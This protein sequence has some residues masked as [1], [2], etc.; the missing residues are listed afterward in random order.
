MTIEELISKAESGDVKAQCELGYKYYYGEEDPFENAIAQIFKIFEN[1]S[2]QQS[3][4]KQNS[5]DQSYLCVDS[6]KRDYAE[7]FK[8]YKK[9]AEQGYA[10]GQFKLGVMYDHGEGVKQDYIEAFK[11]F[12]KAAEQGYALAQCALGYKY[13]NGSGTEKDYTEAVKWYKKAAEQGDLRA[14]SNLGGMYAIIGDFVEAEI[15]L[16]KAA[17][18]GDAVAQ[19]NLGFIYCFG[20][21]VEIDYLE[22]LKWYTKSAEQNYAKA[23]MALGDCYMYGRGVE[24]NWEQAEEWYRRA[25]KNGEPSARD[26]IAQMTAAGYISTYS[27]R[28]AARQGLEEAKIALAEIEKK[29]TLTSEE[30]FRIAH[31]GEKHDVFISWN[32]LDKSIKDG[33]VE[34]IE[35]FAF[36]AEH[37]GERIV[38]KFRA[39]ESDRDAFGDDVEKCIRAA[40]NSAKVFIVILTKNSVDSSWVEKEVGFALNRV[41]AGELDDGDIVVLRAGDGVDEAL[42][43]LDKDSPLLKLKNYAADFCGQAIDGKT[44]GNICGRIQD[45]LERQ[46]VLRY[47]RELTEGKENF[48]CAMYGQPKVAEGEGILNQTLSF[49]KGYIDR[50]LV[51]I[52]AKDIDIV[53]VDEILAADYPF[54]IT[55]EGGVGKSLFVEELIRTRFGADGRF[56]VRINIAEYAEKIAEAQNL[57]DIL[58][59]ELNRYAEK[60]DFKSQGSFTR[61][62]GVND[63]NKMYIVIDG[64]DETDGTGR[65]KLIGLIKDYRRRYGGDRF[66]FTARTDEYFGELNAVLGQNRLRCFKLAALTD[67]DR[68]KLYDSFLEAN[69]VFQSGIKRQYGGESKAIFFDKLKDVPKN[70]CEN[71]MLFSNLVCIYLQGRGQYFPETKYEIISKA[72]E[73]VLCSLKDCAALPISDQ[74]KNYL[75]RDELNSLLGY[76]AYMKLCGDARN[77]SEVIS[78]YV[79]DSDCAEEIY[80]FLTRRRILVANKIAHDI[81]TCYFAGNYI[82]GK[83]YEGIENKVVFRGEQGKNALAEDLSGDGKLRRDTPLTAESVTDVLF[84]LDRDIHGRC[85]AKMNG[86]HPSYETFAKTLKILKP[87]RLSKRGINPTTLA[88]IFEAGKK[89]FYFSDFIFRSLGVKQ[90]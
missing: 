48:K 6:V 47:K 9:A 81:F 2:E 66:I 51:E 46:T 24:K 69:E 31:A 30:T 7:A 26:R 88:Y 63:C 49:E 28:I 8:W 50:T 70:I 74:V 32:H 83:V 76:I 78:E 39:W 85:G 64:L 23:Q 22:A 71:P 3:E 38:T 12:K 68:R 43:K 84:C 60:D 67:N 45:G 19:N 62:R 80:D 36:G 18:R 27:L 57:K 14:Q 55:G 15:W 4:R 40:V 42:E 86:S 21:G 11:W 34:G 56:F 16:R 59:A 79:K 54:M 58:N 5:S 73:I 29:Q 90:S 10:E 37:G 25:L 33:L 1:P 72:A 77:L 82:Y 65:E 61:A 44:I 20:Y 13:E 75:K 35:N 41:E 87:K 17:E 52:T 89:N 53:S